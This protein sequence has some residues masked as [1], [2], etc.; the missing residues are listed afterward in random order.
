ML[1]RNVRKV[2]E[3]CILLS[4]I[5]Q[6]NLG[7]SFSIGPVSYTKIRNQLR[8]YLDYYMLIPLFLYLIVIFIRLSGELFFGKIV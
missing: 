6:L 8:V 5:H 1:L 3:T 7:E 4:G 2:Q